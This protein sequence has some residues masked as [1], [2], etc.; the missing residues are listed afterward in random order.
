MTKDEIKQTTKMKDVLSMYGLKT[1][2][3]GFMC[4]PFHREK[5][6]SCKIY[7]DSFYCFGCGTGGD[8]FTFVMLVEKITFPEAFVKLGGTYI[9]R[10]G[11]SKMQIQREVRDMKAKA[12]K[13]KSQM[14]HVDLSERYKTG[15]GTFP[16][17]SD[18]WLLCQMF[19]TDEKMKHGGAR[20][21][22][23]P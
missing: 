13:P 15:L 14:Q 1:T 8:I 4:C 23:T 20:D 21:G 17:G 22:T 7:E 6:A 18:M 19:D 9:D 3:S 11:K 2:R 5:T 10:K 16:P 12:M